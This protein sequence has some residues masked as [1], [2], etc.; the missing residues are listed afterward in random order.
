VHSGES[1]VRNI[2]ALFFMLGLDRYGFDKKGG[3]TRYTELVFFLCFCIW[4]DLP[5]T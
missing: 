2:Y 4:W 3:E 5:V 1:G